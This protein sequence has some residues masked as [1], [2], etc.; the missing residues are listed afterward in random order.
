MAIRTCTQHTSVLAEKVQTYPEGIQKTETGASVPLQ[1]LLDHT[2]ERIVDM[3][4]EV[5]VRA[6]S[7]SETP[8]NLELVTKWG[9]DGASGQQAV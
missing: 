9:A 7:K 2:V 3:Q 4:E 6:F 5:V 1:S 8:V